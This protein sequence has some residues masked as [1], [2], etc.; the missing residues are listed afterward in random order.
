MSAVIAAPELIE[1]AAT[2][3]AS[4]GSTVSAAHM[5]AAAPTV[6]VTPAA[7]DEVSASIAHLFSLHAQDYQG[8]AGQAAAFHEQFVQHLTA[9]ARSYA[10]TEAASAWSLQ[11]AIA[12]AGSEVSTIA[13]SL[14]QLVNSLIAV[15]G[16]QLPNIL[17]VLGIAIIAVAV[18]ALLI[19]LAPFLPAILPSIT[20]LLLLLLV[21]G[22]I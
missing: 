16:P 3:L 20:P 13:A 1:A 21:R 17:T 4:I 19:V 7:A 22:V 2:D 11:P 12:I 18:I 5:A 6:A 15:V 9:S 14:D 10:S 8:L